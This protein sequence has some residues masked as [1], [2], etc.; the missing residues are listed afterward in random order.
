MADRPRIVVICGS[1]R[2]SGLT[3]LM[4]KHV[5]ILAVKREF[6]VDL[7]SARELQLPMFDPPETDRL[8]NVHRWRETVKNADGI[9]VC[10]PEYHGAFSGVLKNMIDYLDFSDIQHKPVGLVATSGNVKTGV[11]ALNALRLV[12]RALHAPVIVEQAAFWGGDLDVET[13]KL[14]PEPMAQLHTVVDG[15]VRAIGYVMARKAA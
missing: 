3:F 4:M 10:T 7:L 14:K 8:P 5:E 12:F 13:R 9:V 2:N 15:M 1:P 6:E 11:G